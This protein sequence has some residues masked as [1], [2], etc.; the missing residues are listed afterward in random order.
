[1]LIFTSMTVANPHIKSVKKGDTIAQTVEMFGYDRVKLLQ[2]VKNVLKDRVNENKLTQ[3]V[4]L[5]SWPKST[6]RNSSSTRT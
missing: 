6:P 3:E 4:M 1:M 2:N 5:R